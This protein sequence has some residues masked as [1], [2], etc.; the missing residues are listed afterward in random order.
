MRDCR[1]VTDTSKLLL[2]FAVTTVEFFNLA[3]AGDIALL[4]SIEG[5]AIA[6]DFNAQV[7][8]RSQGFEAVAT[9]A[10][11]DSRV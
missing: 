6:A 11:N 4:A 1:L 9:S 7:L 2:S 5:M 8:N 10:A 3:F